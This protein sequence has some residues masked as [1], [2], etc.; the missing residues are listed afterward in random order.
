MIC[1]NNK[2]INEIQVR[3]ESLED[4]SLD[5][6]LT[7]LP[8]SEISRSSSSSTSSFLLCRT[9]WV[10]TLS[11]S[12]PIIWVGW[13]SQK[14][15]YREDLV[16]YQLPHHQ[17]HFHIHNLNYWPPFRRSKLSD[18]F[19]GILKKSKEALRSSAS[20][21]TTTII[22]IIITHHTQPLLSCYEGHIILR[23]KVRHHHTTLRWAHPR[24]TRGWRI[25]IRKPTT[26]TM[27]A[28]TR[29][30][31]KKAKTRTNLFPFW[32]SAQPPK[33]RTTQRNLG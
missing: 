5:S 15:K 20:K 11:L 8:P 24:P 1:S 9:L 4:D 32:E 25:K 33:V 3:V 2:S 18:V 10:N 21:V 19:P 31:L 29:T 7:V 27:V 13:S 17:H 16:G 28:T 14:Y 26:I 12:V 30:S 22:V 6:R 23:W